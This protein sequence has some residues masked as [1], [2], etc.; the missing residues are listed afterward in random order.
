MQG[1][2]NIRKEAPGDEAVV[3]VVEFL[4]AF[5][6]F[7]MILTAFMS[8]AQLELGSNDPYTDLID[9]SAIDGLDRLT[10]SNGYY[11]P[12]IDGV[13]DQN[14]AT[15]EWHQVPVI[16]LYNGL[17]QPGIV[18]NGVLDF[19]RINALP[20]VTIEAMSNGLG[21]AKGLQLRLLI[22]I[23]SSSNSSKIGEVLFE[24]GSDRSTSGTSS[25]ANRKFIN[26]EDII[27]VSLEV[28]DGASTPK[29]LRVTEFSP[30]PVN[31][32]PEWIEIQNQNGFAL[33]MKGWS[34]ERSGTSGTTDYLYKEGVI[35]GGQIG[36]FSG[37]PSTQ[38]TGNASVVY[39]L[40]STG[41]LGVGSVDGLDDTT[42]R[43]R[44]LFAEEDEGAGSIVSQMQWNPS[45]GIVANST[46]VWNGG[47]P[48]SSSS[49]YVS[50]T[51]TPGDV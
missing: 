39:D 28:H 25:V 4:S 3:A 42:G 31:G 48:S 15:T 49:W 24:G 6:L 44:L 41:F 46:V 22:V 2:V 19:E 23:E 47:S 40:G 43:L 21:L 1:G 29:L 14:N 5:T 27:S 18:D 37:D 9:R 38:V 35:P 50:S 51:P 26:G 34:F 30:R 10:S 33:S 12:Y 13:R 45:T 7:L 8:L 17:L 11:V 32:G 20:N 16:D 36:L